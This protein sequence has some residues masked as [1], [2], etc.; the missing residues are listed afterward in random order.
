[1]SALCGG[2][3]GGAWCAWRDRMSWRCRCCGAAGLSVKDRGRE[4]GRLDVL[5]LPVERWRAL[6]CSDCRARVFGCPHGVEGVEVAR[7]APGEIG[8]LALPVRW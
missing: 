8:V 7:G 1:M 6:V 2:R 5:A 3:R 4:C